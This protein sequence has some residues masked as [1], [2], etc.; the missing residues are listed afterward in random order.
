MISFALTLMRLPQCPCSL[1]VPDRRVL[2]PF[3]TVMAFKAASYSGKS[4]ANRRTR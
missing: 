4:Y 3:P 1:R 2:L